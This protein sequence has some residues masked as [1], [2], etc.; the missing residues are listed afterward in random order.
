M[1]GA[2]DLV[3][4]IIDTQKYIGDLHVHFGKINSGTLNLTDTLEMAVAAERRELLRASHSATHLLHAALR[5]RLGGHVTQ[6]GSLVAPGRLRFDISHPGAVG[7]S[8]LTLVEN[9]VNE[10]IRINSPVLTGQMTPDE[11]VEQGAL[12]LFGEKYGDEVRVVSMGVGDSGAYSTEL[13]GGTHVTKTGDIG[14]FTVIGEGAVAAGVRRI[15]ALTGAAALEYFHAQE[16]QLRTAAELLR[17]TPEDLPDRIIAL[18]EERK[19]LERELNRIR[20]SLALGVNENGQASEGAKDVAGIK[21]SGRRL[22]NVPSKELR[23]IVDAAKQKIGSGVVALVAVNEGRA[24]LTIGVT[25]DLTE[26]FSAVDL[27]RVGAAAL[28]GKGGGGRPDMAQAGGPK[29][30]NAD[31]ALEAIEEAIV[32]AG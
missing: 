4:E 9:D 14:A 28:G 21:Y 15:E 6:K 2:D 23:G 24:S 5:N 8:E 12:A 27:V 17:T 19:K 11:A 16:I 25:N 26:R 13:C 1:H 10:Q 18:L 22:E 32:A 20:Q 30:E 31:S 7:L 3:V 29:G